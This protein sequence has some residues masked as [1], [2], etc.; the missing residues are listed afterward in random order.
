MFPDLKVIYSPVGPGIITDETLAGYFKVN[1]IAVAWLICLN[2]RT[3]NY[4]H[5]DPCQHLE[6]G[7]IKVFFLDGHDPLMDIPVKVSDIVVG[8]SKQYL[9]I[10]RDVPALPMISEVLFRTNHVN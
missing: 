10:K 3:G 8:S 9:G 4:Y 5:F 2:L 1:E 6:K 7:N